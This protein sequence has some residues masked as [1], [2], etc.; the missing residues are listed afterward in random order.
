MAK[1]FKSYILT[2]SHPKGHVMLA[3]CDELIDELAIQVWLLNHHSNFKYC[4]L[5]VCGTE[6]WTYG[7]T[8]VLTIRLLDALADLLGRGGGAKN[9]TQSA[10]LVLEC[11]ICILCFRKFLG[12]SPSD[13]LFRRKFQSRN[14]TTVP[15]LI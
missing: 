3:K 2:L 6:L 1:V 14:P 5:F 13:P 12:G 7:R 15:P 10:K 8:G 11:T 9:E 4:T